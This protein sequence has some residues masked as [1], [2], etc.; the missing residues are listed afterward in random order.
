MPGD[1]YVWAVDGKSVSVLLSLSVIERLNA[2]IHRPGECIGVL[3]GVAR[4]NGRT[5]T[6]IVDDF[7][8]LAEPPKSLTPLREH[9]PVGLFRARGADEFRLDAKDAATIERLFHS[10]EMVYLL[11]QPAV[12]EPAKAGFFIQ[13][14]GKIQGFATYREFPLH[15]ALLRSGPFPLSTGRNLPAYQKRNGGIPRIA[16]ILAAMAL[17]TAIGSWA[18]LKKHEAPPAPVAAAYTPPVTGDADRVKPS[19]AETPMAKKLATPPPETEFRRRQ[20]MPT[21]AIEAVPPGRMRRMMARIP[22]LRSLQR[23]RYKAGDQFV[24]PRPSRRPFPAVSPKLAAQIQTTEPIALKLR[25]DQ[26]GRV[27][28]MEILSASRL[29]QLTELA[30]DTAE[31]WRFEPARLN[32]RPVSSDIILHF[33]FPPSR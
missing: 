17:L 10:P 30:V 29:P 21:V 22:G 4:S 7:E 33:S 1:Y 19:P 13:E 2:I 31:R 27:S 5:H 12:G 25:I 26:A 18:L 8:P 15:A 32:G 3:L 11:I 20:A 28:D 23:S 24:Q 16:A 9:K 14:N 6:V